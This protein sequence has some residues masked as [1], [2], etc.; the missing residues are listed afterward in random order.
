MTYGR[1]YVT[2]TK[3]GEGTE[4]AGVEPPIH[5]WV[6]SI[7][8]SG[9]AFYDGN[10]FPDWQGDILV[11]SLKF[12]LLVRLELDNGRVTREQRLLEGEVG[13]IRDVRSGPDGYIYLLTDEPD[14]ELI[15]LE[16]GAN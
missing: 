7:A 5:Y 14:G 12:Q 2:G 9:L 3:I 4:K 10:K 16:P 8:P 13:R 15:R 1:N 6:P 11:G